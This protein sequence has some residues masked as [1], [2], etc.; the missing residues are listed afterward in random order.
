LINGDRCFGHCERFYDLR[1]AREKLEFGD[2][3]LRFL[4]ARGSKILRLIR[5]GLV[6]LTGAILAVDVGLSWLYMY[7]L[8]HP[9]CVAPAHLD[10][11]LPQPEEHQLVTSDGLTMQAWYYPSKNGA[12]ILALGG[13]Q[14]ALGGNLPPIG[15]LVGEGYGV[16]QIDSR[17]CATPAAVV[18]LGYAEV[19]GASAGLN[20]LISRPE[21]DPERIGVMGFSMGG[22]TAIRA[23]ARHPQIAAAVAEGG[24]FNLGQHLAGN[25]ESEPIPMRAL[26]YSIAAAYWLQVGENPWRVSPIDDLPAI[27]P[28]PVLLIYGEGELLGGGGDLQF[29]AA[30]EPKELW[31]VPGGSHGRNYL[32]AE[33]A[34]EAR[35]LDFFNRNLLDQETPGVSRDH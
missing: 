1:R 11:T 23:A 22:A 9:G 10:E 4:T 25:G 13:L 14:G 15:F 8:T 20:F 5:F 7:R 28:R 31:V 21:V 16:L 17:A 6:A 2:G 29:S 34:Y 24:Y 12:A 19:T 32:V 33:E 18:T 26:R 3:E 27:S 35:V 30:R